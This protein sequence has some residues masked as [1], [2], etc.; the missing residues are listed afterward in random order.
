MDCFVATLLARTKR[1][2]M[3]KSVIFIFILLFSFSCGKKEEVKFEA[4]S[5]EAFA[6]DIGDTWEVNA[7]VNVRGFEK[8]KKDDETFVS[9]SYNVDLINS[10]GD[11][12]KN[13]FSDLKEVSDREITDIQLEAQFELDNTQT[14]GTYKIVFNIK[15]N[16]SSKRVSAQ[17]EFELED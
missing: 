1:Y 7:T 9:L 5:P 4:F 8:I 10:N 14:Q 16:N 6:Y 2:K 11:S 15:D 3:N 17:V 13:I 12:T